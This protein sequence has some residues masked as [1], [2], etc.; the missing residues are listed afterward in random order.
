[1]FIS[2][3]V[4]IKKKIKILYYYSFFFL[5]SPLECESHECGD[6]DIFFFFLFAHQ[7]ITRIWHSEMLD[8]SVVVDVQ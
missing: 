5:F 6:L 3:M 7:L 8:V 2:S 4:L 1:M